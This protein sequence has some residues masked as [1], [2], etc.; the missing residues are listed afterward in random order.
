MQKTRSR[1]APMA[2]GDRR[3]AIVDSVLPLLEQHGASVTTRQIA[4]AAGIAEGTIFRAFPDKRALFVEVARRTASTTGWRESMAT[5][6]AGHPDLR[7]KVHAAVE[8]M[9]LRSRRLFVAMSALRGAATTEPGASQAPARPGG[10]P[11]QPPEHQARPGVPPF[12]AEA[13]RELVAI[14][15][16][17]VFEPH[18]TELFVPPDRAAHALS[19]LVTGSWH[20][21]APAQDRLSACEITDVL[22]HGVTRETRRSGGVRCC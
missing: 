19:A 22:L 4:E 15:T 5:R 3:A 16:E 9:V 1:A 7:G 11:D 14:L 18:R 20:P 13:N 6:L 21:A 12:L 17:L 2:A 10:S 8:E